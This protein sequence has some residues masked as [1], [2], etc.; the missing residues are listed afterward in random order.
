MNYNQRL[1]QHASSAKLRRNIPVLC[2]FN[3]TAGYSP[4]PR[5][6]NE[7]YITALICFSPRL[8]LLLSL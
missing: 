2:T 3:V 1:E 4:L 6:P 7:K 8:V 5:S